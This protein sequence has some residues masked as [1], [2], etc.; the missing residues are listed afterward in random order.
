MANRQSSK[1]EDEHRARL[2]ARLVQCTIAVLL[3]GA[4]TR[5]RAG[6][7]SQTPA[8]QNTNHSQVSSPPKQVGAREGTIA[9]NIFEK[10]RQATMVRMGAVDRVPRTDGGRPRGDLTQLHTIDQA[11]QVQHLHDRPATMDATPHMK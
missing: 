10:E 3:F 6:L 7:T 1:A 5:T 2:A 9:Q 4:E 11:R 8:A